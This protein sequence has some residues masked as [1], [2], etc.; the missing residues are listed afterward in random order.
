M[1]EKIICAAIKNE[2]GDIVIGARHY[3]MFMHKCIEL[4]LLAG[5]T[6]RR[7]EIV[8]GFTSNRRPFLTRTEAW[9][10]AKESGQILFTCGGDTANGGTLY[11]E[12]LY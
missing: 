6:W 9:K 1:D 11:S 8:Q 12:N 3:D 2:K 4:R 7:S 10:V 5:E